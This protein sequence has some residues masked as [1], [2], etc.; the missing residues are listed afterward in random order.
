MWVAFTSLL[1]RK[2]ALIK[3]IMVIV[4]ALSRENTPRRRR[5]R[6]RR[7]TRFHQAANQVAIALTRPISPNVFHHRSS[8]TLTR[9][10]KTLTLYSSTSSAV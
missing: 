6:R 3:L 4:V 10:P 5:H 8:L 7:E 2:I 1:S 9:L